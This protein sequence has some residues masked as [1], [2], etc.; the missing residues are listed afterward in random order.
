MVP[1][2]GQHI[3]HLP[4][5]GSPAVTGT[6]NVGHSSG[7]SL[8][9]LPSP[10]TGHNVIGSHVAGSPAVAG[11]TDCVGPSCSAPNG[12]HIFAKEHAKKLSPNQC[13]NILTCVMTC[14]YGYKLGDMAD[15]GCPE[16]ACLQ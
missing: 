13:A 5:S 3:P 4:S 10:G 14:T 2:S 12:L 16:C 6:G 1:A 8:P 9:H 11:T 7:N 15:N